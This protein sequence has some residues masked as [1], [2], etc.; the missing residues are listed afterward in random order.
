MLSNPDAN[1][2]S[3]LVSNASPQC[4]SKKASTDRVVPHDGQGYPVTFFI[5]QT[6]TPMSCP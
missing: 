1:T 5:A 3:G 2:P 4:P 6:V